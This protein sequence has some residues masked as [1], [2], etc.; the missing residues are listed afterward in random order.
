MGTALL[1]THV[2]QLH[3]Y[4]KI[5]VALDPDAGKKTLQFTQEL[6]GQLPHNKVF[7]ARLKDDLK[8]RCKRDMIL[9][10]E[11]IQEFVEQQ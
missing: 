7:A 4:T 11:K 8:Y 2:E 1:S 5:L 3:A 10:K 9:M 6:R